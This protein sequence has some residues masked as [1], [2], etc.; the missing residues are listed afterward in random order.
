MERESRTTSGLKR[1]SFLLNRGFL[2]FRSGPARSAARMAGAAT[3]L[4]HASASGAAGGAAILHEGLDLLDLVGGEHAARR[5]HRF[6]AR[7]LHLALQ[8]VDLIEFLHDRI[9]V[10]I[11]TP[12]QFPQLNLVQLH[13]R[14]RLH[15]SF[16]R[17]YTNLVQARHLL[18]TQTQ[19]GAHARI[20]R[21]A[22]E[23]R[24]AAK[25]ALAAA[26]HAH[27]APATASH[28]H[29][30]PAKTAGALVH[31]VLTTTATR[32]STLA[33]TPL[34]LSTATPLML[35]AWAH[36]MLTLPRG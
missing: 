3:P 13:I 34:T 9:V 36:L 25:S 29:P 28:A 10:G 5:E 19:R 23:A 15:G 18:V 1:Q 17:V 32:K 4:H 20:F 24:A 30:L 12:H 27:S 22:Q 21:H 2:W 33:A 26:P 35:S 6:D 31:A 16:L 14:A 7:L 8:G 11:I